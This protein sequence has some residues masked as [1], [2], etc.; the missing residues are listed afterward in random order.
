VASLDAV[1][2]ATPFGAGAAGPAMASCGSLI[3]ITSTA[4]V[5]IATLRPAEESNP[6]RTRISVS[7]FISG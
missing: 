1:V 3:V 6:W 2:A 7:F 4:I 5:A